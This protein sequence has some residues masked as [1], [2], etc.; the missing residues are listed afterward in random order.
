MFVPGGGPSGQVTWGTA[1]LSM[2]GQ[3]ITNSIWNGTTVAVAYGG[4]GVTTTPANGSLLIGNGTGYTNAT[5]TA[6]TNVTITNSSGGIT[7]AS[8][9]GGLSAGKAIAFA[10]VFGF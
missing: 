9:G 2:A 7:I 3:T 4:T 10:M 5:L 1:G 6:G 8:S